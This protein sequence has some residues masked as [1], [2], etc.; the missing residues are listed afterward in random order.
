MLK[1][2]RFRHNARS[3]PFHTVTCY[4]GA[5][6]WTI[7]ARTTVPGTPSRAATSRSRPR[8]ALPEDDLVFFLLDLIPQLDLTALPPVLRPG[9]PRPT[10]LRR[11]HDGHALG[12][13]LCRGRLLQPQDRR[14]LRTQ[15]G[16][17]SHRR[18]RSARLPHHQR[19]SQDPPGGVEA[20]VPRGAAS[21]RRVGD[22]Q[23]R[24]PV[25]RRD[26]DASQRLAA[27]GDELRLHEQ[28]DRAAGSGDRA[29]AASRPSSSTPSKTRRWEAVVATNC[30]TN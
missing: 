22:G 18:R 23:A 25:H 10:A 19:F 21:G 1:R 5:R 28:G 24:Q 3:S 14:R 16:V 13:C 30:P 9:A 4:A 20:L 6:S 17:P 2:G 8:D 7:D 15:S 26:Q 27:Q 12:L 11:H 29:I